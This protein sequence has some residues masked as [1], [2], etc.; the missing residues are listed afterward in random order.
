MSNLHIFPTT[1]PNLLILTAKIPES[2]LLLLSTFITHIF[3]AFFLLF[4]FVALGTIVLE[5]FV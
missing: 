3:V 1:T 4:V 2:L 5:P